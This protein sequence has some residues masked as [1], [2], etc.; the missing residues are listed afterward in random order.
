METIS[1]RFLGYKI[2]AFALLL[3]PF[4]LSAGEVVNDVIQLN[5]IVVDEVIAP[6]SI[7][8][9]CAAVK[10]AKGAIS[11][12]GARH[13]EGGQIAT[14]HSLHLDMR[15]F[16]KIV[17]FDPEI[18]TITVQ[19][20]ITWRDIQDKIDPYNLSV[21]IMQSYANF[22]VGGSLS[23]NCHGRYVGAGPIILSVKGIKV[24]LADG[25]V[26][27]ATPEAH[28]DIFYAIIGGYG[29]IGVIVEAT[30]KLTD[31]TRVERRDEVMPINR[32]K[33]Y[34]FTEIR[35]NPK[36]V[37]HNGDIYPPRFNTVRA[38]TWSETDKPVTNKDRLIGRNEN[39]WLDRQLI[40]MTS[41]LPFGKWLRQ[42]VF[43]PL[44]YLRDPVVWRNHE[45]SYDVAELE[46]VSRKESTYVLQE[47]FVPVERFDEFYPKM[48]GILNRHQVNVM[49]ISIRYAR[50]DPG[51]LLAWAKSEVFAFV[52][53]YKQGTTEADKAAVSSWTR[54]LIDAALSVD[55]SYYLPYQI[56]A[57][58][59]QF[60]KAYPR[61]NEFF[62][63]K[64]RLDPENKFRNKL[65]DAY[66]QASTL[67]KQKAD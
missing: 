49:N 3:L 55:G 24:V 16:N 62:A 61:S 20:G 25:S 2:L 19:A 58:A 41:K 57:T 47:Y 13:S 15:S 32:Y 7:E 35:N 54:E 1:S 26:V 67:V 44:T 28:S 50:Q 21:S 6:V 11:I 63:L 53:Y 8:E 17:A 43:D 9:I 29:G 52:L 37:F 60:S 23:V 59:E 66:Y 39:Y 40:W 4:A 42:Y 48:A 27:E 45:A 14:E 5:P 12:G 65:W 46:P 18:K 56:H 31:N 10:N 30:L 38:V 36:A 33:D 51:S 22:T 64:T 34:F